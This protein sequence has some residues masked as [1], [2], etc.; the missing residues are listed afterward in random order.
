MV[1]TSVGKVW[2]VFREGGAARD[3][4]RTWTSIFEARYWRFLAD[5]EI[6]QCTIVVIPAIICQLYTVFLWSIFG[7]P[8][9]PIFVFKAAK[10]IH[11][12]NL[13]LYTHLWVVWKLLKTRCFHVCPGPYNLLSNLLPSVRERILPAEGIFTHKL[14]SWEFTIQHHYQAF[15]TL[16][17]MQLL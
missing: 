5:P 12:V 9:G 11:S 1:T 3:E 16:D 4:G 6:L 13:C 15:I 17:F 7:F 2:S 14:I 8:R 10:H